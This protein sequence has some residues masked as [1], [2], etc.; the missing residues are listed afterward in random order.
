M[1]DC[2]ID[3]VPNFIRIPTNTMFPFVLII[4]MWKP[5]GLELNMQ[6]NSVVNLKY[7]S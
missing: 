4:S 3:L 7:K 2:R 5:V 1:G 6:P